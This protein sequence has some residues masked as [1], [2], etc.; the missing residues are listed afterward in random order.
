LIADLRITCWG[1][2]NLSRAARDLKINK[3]DFTRIGSDE[4]E[5]IFGMAKSWKDSNF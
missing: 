3:I 5:K 2:I 1:V 4:C